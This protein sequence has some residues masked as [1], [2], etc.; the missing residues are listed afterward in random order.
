MKIQYISIFANNNME[1]QLGFLTEKLGFQV[2]K[3]IHLDASFEGFLLQQPS[4]AS[5]QIS[6]ID[7]ER[8]TG[9]ATI[10]I[11]NT[12]DCIKD[13]HQLKVAGVHFTAGPSYTPSGMFAKFEDPS[14]NSY[15]LLEERV[16]EESI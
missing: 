10:V 4:D 15:I 14:G 2:T 11:L 1:E 3:K 16:Y 8:T 13:Y 6:L 7:S 9:H 5:L 12:L